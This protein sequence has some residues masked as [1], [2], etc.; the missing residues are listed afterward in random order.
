MEEKNELVDGHVDGPDPDDGSGTPALVIE[1]ERPRR[2][3]LVPRSLLAV[4]LGATAAVALGISLITWYVAGVGILVPDVTDITEGVARARLAQAGLAVS[5]VERRFDIRP[6][7]TVLAQEPGE[8]TRLPR[9]GTVALVVSAGTE[10]FVMPD[11]TGVDITVA[12]GQLEQRGLVVK[13]EAVDSDEPSDTVIETIPAPGVTVRTSDIVRVRIASDGTASTALLPFPLERAVFVIDPQPV[14]AEDIDP[15]ME[16]ARRLRSL[17]EASGAR[18]VITRSVSEG[19]MTLADRAQRAAETTST[20]TAVIG[21]DVA[22]D[23]PTGVG[24]AVPGEGTVPP[25]QVDAS[26]DLAEGLAVIFG[27]A[28]TAATLGTLGSDPVAAATSAPAIRVRLGAFESREDA[29]A[30]RDP[31]WSD[32]VARAIYRSLGERFAPR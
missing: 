13:I 11:V 22:R 14:S 12:R 10:E 31:S 32:T 29:A 17:L 27:E 9:G 6:A 30:F 7:G 20:V 24:I 1:R 16:V 15:P 8:G 23:A 18:V 3:P 4:V 19:D 21:L 5:T 26:Q 2:R 28:G 25:T